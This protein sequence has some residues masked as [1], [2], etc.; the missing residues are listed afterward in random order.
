MAKILINDIKVGSRFR[1]KFEDIEAL[2]ASIE[3]FGLLNPIV[4]DEN[5]ELIAGE[6]R[7][8]AHQLLGK[9]E[10]EVKYKKELTD[11]EKKEIE[12]EENI[13]RKAFTWQ[14]EVTAKK[15]IHQLKQD[16]HGAGVKGRKQE[17]AWGMRDTAK[18]LGESL[19]TTTMD[20]QLARGLKAF[21][22]LL[23]E[24][25]KT[26][27]FKKMKLKQ[28][29]I[30]HQALSERLKAKGVLAH[31]DIIH[32][33]CLNYMETMEPESVDLILT[34][35]PYGIDIAKAH[36]ID[37]QACND[38][39]FEDGDFET[40]NLLDKAFALMYKVLKNERHMYLFC[41]IDK[42][43]TVIKLLEKHGFEVHNLPL[44]WDKGSGS[45]PSQMTSYVHSYEVFL[46]V[47]KGPHRKLNGT[48]RDIFQI[49]RAPSNKKIHPTEKPT[50]LLRDLIEYSSHPGE[51]VFDPFA[52]SGSTLE[53][54]KE[55]NR[56]GLGVEMNDI[57]Y[58][59]ICGRLGGE[60][61]NVS[62]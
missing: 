51:L 23:K 45:Y 57:Y 31:P 10:I 6:R 17:G 18:A 3:R 28:E 27:A 20:I 60:D 37:R 40:M 47:W 62:E 36:T 7:L 8:R 35:P 15:A 13:Q 26:A 59:N 14:E 19:G 21:P 43:S 50:E 42:I 44:V 53:A 11:L 30:L 55:K 52:G 12:L 22:E 34:D 61:E 9:T 56:R 54:A 29:A 5:N 58:K 39:K 46:H 24:K 33:S 16:F 4:I 2:A 1:E 38:I 41:G 25:S 32:D 48:P 49:K